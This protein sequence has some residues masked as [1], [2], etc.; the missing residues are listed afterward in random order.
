MAV[1][2]TPRFTFYRQST[3]LSLPVSVCC[4]HRFDSTPAAYRALH[5]Q[6]NNSYGN[7]V[8]LFR[9]ASGQVVL[10]D[11]TGDKIL[12]SALS[13]STWYFVGAVFQTGASNLRL[14]WRAEGATSLSS[15]TGTL[16]AIT[17]SNQQMVWAG[18]PAAA[19][20]QGLGEAAA[21]CHDGAIAYGRVFS[22]ALTSSDFLA[23]SASATA[24]AAEYGDWAFATTANSTTDSS[25]NGNTLTS[26]GTGSQANDTNPN[27]S[28]SSSTAPAML[29][30][31]RQPHQWGLVIRP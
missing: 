4:W 18:G 27:I 31:R 21:N 11:A 13:N 28:L 12:S 1:D 5:V 9:N 29:R 19:P 20:N 7:H 16:G 25:G 14:Y 17:Y 10:S 2:L 24:I 23:E 8:G 26:V 22:G 3:G 30:R 15:G 6:A